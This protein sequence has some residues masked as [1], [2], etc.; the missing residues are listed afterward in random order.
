V[1]IWSCEFRVV[2]ESWF[3]KKELELEFY[4]RVLTRNGWFCISG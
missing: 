2:V 1:E 4:E 3:A